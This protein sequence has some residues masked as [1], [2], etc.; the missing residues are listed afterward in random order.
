MGRRGREY[1]E[2]HH[3]TPVLADKLIQCIEQVGNDG[4][5]DYVNSGE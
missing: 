5:W 3:A 4:D 2:K 1:V